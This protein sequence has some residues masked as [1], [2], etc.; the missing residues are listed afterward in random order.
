MIHFPLATLMSAGL[1]EILI[2]T[3]P[4]DRDSFQRLLDDGSQLGMTLNYAVQDTPRGL[5]E[6]FVIG[7]DFLNGSSVGLILGDNLFHGEK[8]SRR[9]RTMHTIT[10]AEVFA[11]EVANPSSYGVIEFDS[12]GRVHS[13]TEKPEQPA[14]SY[15][16]PGL[17]FYDNRVV[18]MARLLTPSKRGELEITDINRRYLEMGDL[19]VTVLP[20]GTA[21][22]DTGTFRSLLEAGEYVRVLEERQGIRIGC[23]EEVAWRNGWID[24]DDLLRLAEP[25][26]RSGY[27]DYL[28][29]LVAT[30]GDRS[31]VH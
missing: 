19:Q 20:R 10:G 21:W 12:S 14:S 6:A 29:R 11:V 13:L 4:E 3:T 5:A 27:G 23:I 7:S 8:L 15:A 9:L 16:V 17:Y 1:R 22:L 18:D 30:V 28:L 25:L 2:I 31:H 26:I 24:D